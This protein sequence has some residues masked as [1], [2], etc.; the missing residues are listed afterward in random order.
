MGQSPNES[1]SFETNGNIMEISI[2]VFGHSK[3]G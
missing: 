2:S 3:M 1:N